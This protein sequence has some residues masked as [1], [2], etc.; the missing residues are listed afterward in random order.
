MRLPGMDGLE[1]QKAL[2]ASGSTMPIVFLTAFEDADLR[3][4]AMERGAVDFLQKPVEE[5]V[6]FETIRKA[7]ARERTKPPLPLR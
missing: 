2:A 3:L 7:Q 1:L 5:T 4:E 6:L